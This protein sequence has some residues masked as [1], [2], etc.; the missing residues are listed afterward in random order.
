[1]TSLSLDSGPARSDSHQ[2]TLDFSRTETQNNWRPLAASQ[3]GSA[4]PNRQVALQHAGCRNIGLLLVP[5]IVGH[6]AIGFDECLGRTNLKP[7]A[8][9]D[10]PKKSASRLCQVP[11]LH[12]RERTFRRVFEQSRATDR[13]GGVE[14]HFIS[15]R[16]SSC[17]GGRRPE[18][19]ISAMRQSR[20][21]LVVFRKSKLTAWWA[22]ALEPIAPALSHR[23]S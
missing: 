17:T 6:Y 19:Q 10:H 11:E 9:I 1:M 20:R 4:T 2:C 22:G 15:S 16:S 21:S 3:S 8:V 5:V 12:Q 23:S 14:A 13:C 18:L 7:I